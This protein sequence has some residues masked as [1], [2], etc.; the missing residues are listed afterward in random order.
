MPEASGFGDNR[1]NSDVAAL[2]EGARLDHVAVAVRDIAAG[3]RLFRD[4]LGGGFLFGGDVEPQAFRFAQYR[5]PGGGK[6]ELVTPLGEGFVSRFLNRHGEGVHHVTLKVRVIEEQVAR[7]KAAGVPL[8][9]VNFSNPNWKEAFIHPREAHGVLI[10]LAESE[11]EDDE[12]AAHMRERF[13]EAA[14]LG[15]MSV[16]PPRA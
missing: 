3:A 7:L 5:V 9:L 11:H 2:V 6:V 15:G 16:S 8:T 13:S 1:L 4:V 12:L 14:L 10:Q